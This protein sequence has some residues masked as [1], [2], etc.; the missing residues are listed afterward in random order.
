VDGRVV[1]PA[2]GARD[3][4]AS[5]GQEPSEDHVTERARELVEGGSE[6]APPVAGD[7]ETAARAA[8]RILEDSEARTADP[9][10]IDPHDDGVIRRSS[11]ETA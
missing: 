6:S 8:R 10:T 2:A 3:V 4:G 7:E 1:T 11:E 5:G 9:A